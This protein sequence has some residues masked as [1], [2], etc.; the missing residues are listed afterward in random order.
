MELSIVRHRA[1]RPDQRIGSLLVNPGGPG[2]GGI[3]FAL[4][5]PAI[6]GTRLVE[7]FD[8]IGWD[9][10]GTG[11]SEPAIDCVDGYDEY[12]AIDPTPDTP[13]EEAATAAAAEAFS[14]SCEARSGADLLAHVSTRES[15]TDMDRIRRALGDEQISYFGFSYGSELGATWATL[16][17]ETVRAAVFDGAVDPNRPDYERDIDQAAGFEAAL[18]AF[19]A[20]CGADVNCPFHNDGEPGTALDRLLADLDEQPLAVSPDRSP[21]NQ[22]VAY[23][24]IVN[25]LYGEPLWPALAQALADAQRGDGEGLLR[26]YDEYFQRLPD[27]TYANLLEAFVAIS[28]V[29]SDPDGDAPDDAELAGRFQAAAPRLWPTFTGADF[30][31]SWPVEPAG[32]VPITAAGAGPILVVGT[33]GDPATPLES[34]RAMA[35]AL[36]EGAFVVVE[37]DQHTGYG[38]NECIDDAV[39]DYLIE[40]TVPADG[41]VCS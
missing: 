1:T 26:G 31:S 4:N 40:L 2:A 16:F 24:A 22:G 25:A 18:D 14:A 7:R 29:D 34:S 19:L 8:I 9:P 21:V 17:P 27:G 37:A 12:F 11:T 30:C 33:T 3:D 41:L 6:Y 35:D 15:A 38:L 10:R 39:E 23:M 28:C 5:A 13:E 36:D 20:D 32:S